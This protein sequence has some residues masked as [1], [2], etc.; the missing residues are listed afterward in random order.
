[1]AGS[2]RLLVGHRT[3]LPPVAL[4]GW[5]VT[6]TSATW[7]SCHRTRRVP[8]PR[9]SSQVKR[10]ASVSPD[11]S[12]DMTVM[13]LAGGLAASKAAIASRPS[14]EPAGTLSNRMTAS[15]VNVAV[16]VSQL[17]MRTA[18]LNRRLCSVTR[19]VMTCLASRLLRRL[20]VGVGEQQFLVDDHG[21]A[22]ALGGGHDDLRGG[23]GHSRRAAHVP[24]GVHAGHGG[25][26]Q[27]ID[28]DRA[29]LQERAAEFPSQARSLPRR[30]GD[31]QG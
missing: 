19:L 4:C 9:P 10:T 23:V 11:D 14:Y 16:K 29:V 21:S 18:S 22:G 7:S 8:P 31:E 1:M 25:L 3:V 6:V 20:R 2:S 5:R 27:L 30:R 13:V 12:T 26:A 17:P 28:L 15:G 24:G